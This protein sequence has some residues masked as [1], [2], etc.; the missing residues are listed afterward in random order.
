MTFDW[1][2]TS[3]KKSWGYN[4]ESLNMKTVNMDNI[5]ALSLIIMYIKD[6]VLTQ[7]DIHI[8]KMHIGVLRGKM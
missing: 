1:M 7:E 2:D 3:C 5:R 4:W 6:I 8:L